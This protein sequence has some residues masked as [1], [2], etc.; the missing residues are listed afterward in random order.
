MIKNISS[1]FALVMAL[2]LI[3]SYSY[4]RNSEEGKETFEAR[5]GDLCHQL[6]EPKMLSFNQWKLVTKVMQKRMAQDGT[7]FCGYGFQ[8]HK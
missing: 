6:P 7:W 1:I 2:M 8:C 5:C 4:A 3:S